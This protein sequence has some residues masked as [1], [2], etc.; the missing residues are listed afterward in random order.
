VVFKEAVEVNI[1]S[2]HRR[3][4]PFGL[5]GGAPGKTGEQKVIKKNGDEILLKG[6]DSAKAE[7]GDRVVIATPGGGGCGKPK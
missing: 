2:Q 7:A 6:M 4:A 1:L 5:K 3:V